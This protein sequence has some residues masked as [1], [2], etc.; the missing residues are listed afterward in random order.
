MLARCNEA[1]RKRE[2]QRESQAVGGHEVLFV[3]FLD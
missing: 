3:L 2:S 1:D